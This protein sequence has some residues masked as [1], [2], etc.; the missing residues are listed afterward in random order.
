MLTDEDLKKI[1]E[2]VRKHTRGSGEG[3]ISIAVLIF[4]LLIFHGCNR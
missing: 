1:D 3:C 4:V 2:I